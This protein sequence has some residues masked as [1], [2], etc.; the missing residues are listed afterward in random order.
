MNFDIEKFKEFE[1]LIK[2]N[3]QV[4]PYQLTNKNIILLSVK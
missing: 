2:R 1:L 3:L 4:A